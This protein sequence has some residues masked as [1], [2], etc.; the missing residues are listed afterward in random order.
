[1]KISF[2]KEEFE[3]RLKSA[4]QAVIDSYLSL[5]SN[6]TIF[7][8]VQKHQLN[9]EQTQELLHEIHTAM[10][11]FS[12]FDEITNCMTESLGMYPEEADAEFVKIDREIFKPLGTYVYNQQ[13]NIS[14]AE[15][16]KRKLRAAGV[17]SLLNQQDIIQEIENPSLSIPASRPSI[18]QNYS[19]TGGFAT[20]SP[21]ANP[22]SNIASKLDQKLSAPTA[23]APRE[24]YQVKK[25][26]PYHEPII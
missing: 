7:E 5:Y 14:I 6:T 15:E 3:Q 24:I 25:P 1:M 20:S 21:S 9:D 22:A 12:S 26:D 8:I 19:N 13:K 23:T 4:P 17:S 11:G 18:A 16:E 10:V 2:T